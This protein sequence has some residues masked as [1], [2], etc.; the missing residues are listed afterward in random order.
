MAVRFEQRHLLAAA[1]N[2]DLRLQ[3]AADLL[4][5]SKRLDFA[6]HAVADSNK[7]PPEYTQL[8]IAQYLELAPGGKE[9]KVNRLFPFAGQVS[10]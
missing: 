4:V 9:R 3:G 8:W 2:H 6:E 5:F 1:G 10:P 7:T